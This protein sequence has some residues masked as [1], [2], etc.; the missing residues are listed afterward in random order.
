MSVVDLSKRITDNW[1]DYCS[2]LKSS[3]SLIFITN[4]V[5]SKKDGPC[6]MNLTVGKQWYDTRKKKYFQIPDKGL[7][8]RPGKSKMIETKQ[9]I[10][11]PY[12]VYG[13]LTGTGQVI[14]QGGFISCGKINPSHEGPL[15]IGFYNGSDS[16]IIFE[17][18][19]LL[20]CCTFFDMDTTLI[21][22]LQKPYT[23]PEPELVKY[24]FPMKI[25]VWLSRNWYSV[26]TLLVA[27]ASAVLS[28]ISLLKKGA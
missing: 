26:L 17:K 3:E 8:I 14:L 12:N 19:D 21:N 28:L 24:P 10:C 15:R 4:A 11:L 6:S 16:T 1:D 5:D 13:E 23:D 18:D 27:L 2:S 20:A 9:T 7:K 22:K 25:L